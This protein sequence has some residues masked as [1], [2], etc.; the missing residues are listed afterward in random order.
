MKLLATLVLVLGTASVAAAAPCDT[1]AAS[2][3]LPHT[4][5]TASTLVAAGA[6]TPPAPVAPP[7]AAGAG[8]AA[9][10][11]G[12][13]GGGRGPRYDV[14]PAFCRVS[15]VSKPTPQSNIGI[16]IWM[17]ASGWNGK[18]QVTGWAFWGGA[19]NYGALAPVLQ[20]GYA[21]ATTDGGHQDGNSAMFAVAHGEQ[22]VD[23]SER[24]WHET[25]VTAKAAIAA[26]YGNAPSLSVFNTCGGGTRQALTEVQLYPADYDAVAAGG[27]SHDTNRF[28]FTQSWLFDATHRDPAAYIPATKFPVIHAAAVAACD[29]GD[30]A[31]DGIIAQPR[32]CRF[33]PAVLACKAGDAADCLTPAQVTAVKAI[34]EGPKNPRTGESIS[35][36][37]SIGSELGWNGAAAQRQ[38][39]G[40]N[41]DFL[42]HFVFRDPAWNPETRP[43]N[44][45][46]DVALARVP[47]LN[48]LGATEP[49]ISAF[50]NRG[51]KLLMYG[52][53]NDT[54]I[55]TR[56]ATGYYESVVKTVGEAKARDAMRLFMIPDMGHCPA[57]ATAQDGYL[58]DPLPVL[59]AWKQSDKAPASITV[60]HRTA[61]VED[62]VTA[63]QPYSELKE[64]K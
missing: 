22:L 64:T 35:G 59:E 2:L 49:D 12:G 28:V 47:I 56:V 48:R 34:Y 11:R 33:D 18:F 1:L 50:I 44:Y 31:V 32:A 26:F 15:A 4:M 58:F 21:T 5:V 7:A 20:A 27:L 37:M 8:P 39:G 38:T 10:G 14:L 57:A 60:R 13:G 25:T 30:G 42:R 55:P 63:V 16:E 46:S 9:A 6:F 51:G 19:I 36:G 24:A 3:K 52:G 23:W 40:F 62:R 29:A 45:D 61:G 43:L 54:A 41:V 53:W 17:P